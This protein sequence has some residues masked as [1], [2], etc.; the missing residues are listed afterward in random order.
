[1]AKVWHNQSINM[2]K[3]RVEN[4]KMIVIFLDASALQGVDC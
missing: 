4:P 3:L 1:M 2:L